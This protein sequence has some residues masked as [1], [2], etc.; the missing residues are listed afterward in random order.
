MRVLVVVLS[1][2][3]AGCLGAPSQ[4]ADRS[5]V[6]PDPPAAVPALRLGDCEATLHVWLVPLEDLRGQTPAAFPP[7]IYKAEGEADT[8]LGRVVFYF[9]DCPSTLVDGADGGRSLLGLLAIRVV[10]PPELA[11]PAE[12]PDW[13]STPWASMYLLDAFVVGPAADALAAAAIAASEVSG[14]VARRDPPLPG[15]PAADVT[16]ATT[17][18]TFRSTVQGNPQQVENFSRPE[19]YFRLDDD[20]LTVRWLDVSFITTLWE[21]QGR[22]EVPPGSPWAMAVEDRVLDAAVDHHFMRGM[23]GLAWNET[24]LAL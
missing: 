2:V 7:A 23:V 8:P 13:A 11:P 16:V 10:A 14:G 5:D 4:Q 20:G 22:T 21:S 12:K 17:D 1:V 6:L 15:F 3:V 18:G 24:A 19:R 9:Y